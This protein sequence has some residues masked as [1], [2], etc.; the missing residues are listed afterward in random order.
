VANVSCRPELHGAT[1]RE[2]YA[3]F[4]AGM[5]EFG[6]EQTILRDGALHHLPTGEYLAVN[7]STPM[8]LLALK[9]AALALQITG[10]Q[11]LKLT[12]T[13]VR[14]PADIYIYGL[15]EEVSYASALVAFGIQA[16]AAQPSYSALS[17][18]AAASSKGGTL[19]VPNGI[20]DYLAA[21]SRKG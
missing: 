4:H 13:P 8:N 10:N 3:K 21:L 6:F 12:L 17:A 5:K 1:T 14:D 11:C 19:P 2:Q 7:I 15:D 20:G 16:S 18:L 9:I